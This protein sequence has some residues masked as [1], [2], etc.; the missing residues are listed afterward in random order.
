MA[1]KNGE[2]LGGD[3]AA[4]RPICDTEWLPTQ[5]LTPK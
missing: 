3:L 2:A 1:E 5:E 4:S